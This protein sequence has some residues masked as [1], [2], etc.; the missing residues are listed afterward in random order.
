MSARS[1]LCELAGEPVEVEAVVTIARD[2]SGR[3]PEVEITH[4]EGWE[5]RDLSDD[6]RDDLKEQVACQL[7]E[8]GNEP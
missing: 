3:Y 8:E 7:S 6:D 5:D 1:F 4:V 2:E